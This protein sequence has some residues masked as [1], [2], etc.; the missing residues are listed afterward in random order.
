MSSGVPWIDRKVGEAK[1][2]R[3]F[4]IGIG[5]TPRPA[6]GDR[7]GHLPYP[8]RRTYY[9]VSDGWRV[10][11]WHGVFSDDALIEF[12]KARGFDPSAPVGPVAP[13]QDEDLAEAGRRMP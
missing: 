5:L 8:G 11:G 4:L 10:W 13:G 9:S 1:A 3:A 6:G 7:H 2:A 12:A